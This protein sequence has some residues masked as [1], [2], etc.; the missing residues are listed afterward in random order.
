M[1]WKK[2]GGKTMTELSKEKF[3][4]IGCDKLDSDA[5]VRPT[6]TYWKDAWR[7]LKENP[8]AMISLITLIIVFIM[9]IIGPY[10]RGLDFMTINPPDK[11]LSPNSKYWFGTDNL[12]RDLFSRIWYGAR[13]SVLVAL[14]CT[15][16]QVVV[17]SIYGGVMAYFGGWVDELLMRIIEVITSIP[18]LL[19]TILVMMVLGNGV[20][21]LLVALCITSWCGTARQM[22]GQIMQLRESEYVMAAQALGASS[23]RV[24]L[25]HLI[26]NTLGILILN[27]ASSIPSYIFT[28]SGLSFLGIG[29]QSP[30]TSLGVLIST[31]Q[32]AMEFYP[33]QVFFPALIIC[34]MVLAFNLLGDGLRDALDPRLRQ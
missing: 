2:V 4:V 18:S 31:G 19:I 27:T 11:N 10:I 3:K 32:Q 29:L 17:G 8:V 21:S 33:Y 30:N 20:F 28:E 7:R 13:V 9:V 16:I 14:I 25:K 24:I 1:W 12:G 26:P 6:I 34:I 23:K 5:I 15:A 22:R